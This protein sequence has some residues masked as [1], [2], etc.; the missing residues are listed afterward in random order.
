MHIPKSG[1]LTGSH[2]GG[3]SS[4]PT[5]IKGAATCKKNEDKIALRWHYQDSIKMTEET[6]V[7]FLPQ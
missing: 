4:T 5:R 2:D 7:L 1:V 3:G 6:T